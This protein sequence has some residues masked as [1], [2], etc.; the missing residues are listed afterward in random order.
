MD[1]ERAKQFYSGLFGWELLLGEKD[2]S[3]YLHIKNGGKFIGGI[4]PAQHRDPGTPPHWL[5]Y[6]Y[7]RDV[8]ESAKKAQNLGA[9]IYAPATTIE[10]VGRMAVLADP[11]G[12]V[13][14][15][16]NESPRA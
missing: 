1:P 14:A 2:P 12:A 16:F 7:V 9:K 3:G 8:D 13:F 10:G 15:L 5:S 6:F 11:Q 4:P